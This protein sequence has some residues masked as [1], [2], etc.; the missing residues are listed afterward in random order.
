MQA[1]AGQL[2]WLRHEERGRNSRAQGPASGL[3]FR[4]AHELQAVAHA[5]LYI[6]DRS[7]SATRRECM[8]AKRIQNSSSSRRTSSPRT[9]DFL[10]FTRSRARA[11]TD[12]ARGPWAPCSH[13]YS[14][15]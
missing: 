5:V 12:R 4:S 15:A 6:A 10:S 1:R 14:S 7:D 8:R 2:R 11:G 3:C 13:A 9:V